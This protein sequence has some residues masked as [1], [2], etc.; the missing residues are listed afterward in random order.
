MKQQIEEELREYENDLV[1]AECTLPVFESDVRI[2]DRKITELK[3]RIDTLKRILHR[4]G[5]T[6]IDV[7]K[8][9]KVK[10]NRPHPFS[11]GGLDDST[12]SFESGYDK[13]FTDGQRMLRAAI[14]K[15]LK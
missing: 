5:D 3:I 6:N 2:R 12:E 9:T 13:G 4:Y 14:V 1:N 7:V 11:G 15:K 10:R 8:S